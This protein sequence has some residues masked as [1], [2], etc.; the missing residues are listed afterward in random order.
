MALRTREQREIGAMGQ[1][2][3][4]PD[5]GFPRDLAVCGFLLSSVNNGQFAADKTNEEDTTSDDRGRLLSTLICPVRSI[6]L[7]CYHW[8]PIF[9]YP[10]LGVY[11]LVEWSCGMPRLKIT[12]KL[13]GTT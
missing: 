5:F 4:F 10:A 12:D 2:A 3:L 6:T 9:Y 1:T 13:A 11:G 8:R 7:I